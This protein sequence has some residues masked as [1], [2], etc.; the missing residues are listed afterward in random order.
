MSGVNV[1]AVL[2]RAAESAGMIVKESNGDFRAVI[3]QDDL[4]KARAAIAE[5]IE[6]AD[7]VQAH[8]TPDRLREDPKGRAL[9]VSMFAALAALAA[10]EPQS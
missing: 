2:D 5:L 4:F 3:Y 8:F 1:L 6:R 10:V 7:A 9:I